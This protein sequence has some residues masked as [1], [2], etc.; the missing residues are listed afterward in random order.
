[1]I[2]YTKVE[3]TKMENN[4]P[5]NTE[6][7]TDKLNTANSIPVMEEHL[8]LGKK[9]VET[10]KIHVSKKVSE[11]AFNADMPVFKEEVIVERKPVDRYVDDEVPGIRMNGDTTIIPV[12][13][14]VVVKRMLLVEEIYITKRR[15]ESTATVN[16]VLRK[17]EVTINRSES[18][19]TDNYQSNI[20][21]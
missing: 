13:K 21:S 3:Y 12:V 9:V 20:N 15:I 5:V 2:S 4:G 7:N 19:G 8:H 17:E 10:G 16:E 1:L 11:H 18:P 14:E 6:T